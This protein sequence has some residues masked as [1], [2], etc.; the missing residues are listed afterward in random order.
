[1]PL[2]TSHHTNHRKELSQLIKSGDIAVEHIDK[3]L[4]ASNTAPSNFAWKN[5]LSN[6][7][8]WLGVTALSSSVM[9]FIAYNWD[10]MGRFAKFGLVELLIAGSIGIYWKSYRD[11]QILISTTATPSSLVSAS[12]KWLI[13]QIALLAASLFVGVLLAFY[14]QTYQTGADPWQ[15]FFV[16]GLLIIPWVIIARLPSLW[17]VWLA[18][19]NLSIVLY[20]QTFGSVLLSYLSSDSQVLWLFFIIN[21]LAL[22]IWEFVQY[23]RKMK[24]STWATSVILIAAGT[25]LTLL[26][27]QAIFSR[28][29]HLMAPAIFW[30]LSLVA[31]VIF[32]RSFKPNLFM[33]AMACLSGIIVIISFLTKFL[34]GNGAVAL[35][36]A[37]VTIGLGVSSAVWLKKVHHEFN[38]QEADHN[39]DKKAV[40]LGALS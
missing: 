33:L 26:V 31:I 22:F 24:S 21:T 1:M 38:D 40:E 18:L 20:Y 19:I 14:G 35:F 29:H 3:A 23:R 11:Y 32:Y 10:E 36:L 7:L 34:S 37:M 2:N 12:S 5:F 13:S 17:I 25:P 8:L 4:F 6:L 15:L 27:L 9:F 30:V 28:H 16:W 39:K